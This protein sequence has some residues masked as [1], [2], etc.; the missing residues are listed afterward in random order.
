MQPD[1][2]NPGT[3]ADGTGEALCYTGCMTKTAKQL[4]ERVASWPEED[5]EKLEEAARQIEAWRNGEYHATDEELRA[6]D[7]A[8]AELD[9]G[10]AASDA[11]YPKNL[12]GGLS[13][14]SARAH[15]GCHCEAH[16][17]EAIQRATRTAWI[18]PSLRS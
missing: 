14:R 9:R 6:I 7:E 16:T 10:A 18:A 5:I 12:L 3:G 15:A 4:F 13:A 1:A 2:G 8:I 11:T 17:A